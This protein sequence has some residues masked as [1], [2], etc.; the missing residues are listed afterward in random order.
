MH[1]YHNFVT[2]YF[3]LAVMHSENYLANLASTLWRFRE[4]DVFCDTTIAGSGGIEL[5]A[6][7]VVLAAGSVK[8]CTVL[9]DG[10][11]FED[12]SGRKRYR[13]ELA[14]ADP[15][16]LISV[17]K[18]IYTGELDALASSFL[19][20]EEQLD[21]QEICKALGLNVSLEMSQE[22]NR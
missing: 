15:S 20:H 14:N 9:N 17:L 5:M 12:V 3:R 16:R 10:Q 2:F 18:Y 21:T 1:F 4:D 13:L 19:T 22:L 6:H 8:L 7:S 11:P